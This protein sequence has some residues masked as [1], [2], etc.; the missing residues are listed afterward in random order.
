MELRGR[1]VVPSRCD[2]LG[3]EAA[4]FKV[5]GVRAFPEFVG[6]EAVAVCGEGL[7][8][9]GELVGGVEPWFCV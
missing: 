9:W 8:D 3:D 2:G 7:G 6:G 4:F 5:L 1:L